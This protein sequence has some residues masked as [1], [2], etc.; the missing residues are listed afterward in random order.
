MP[1]K[2]DN[3][4]NR[5]TVHVHPLGTSQ[6]VETLVDPKAKLERDGGK[7]TVRR[8]NGS[9]IGTEERQGQL[10]YYLDCASCG[11]KTYGATVLRR[12][13]SCHNVP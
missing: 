10:M 4:P 2:E 6:L 11:I 8:R 12:C 7:P 13:P 3:R 1:S 9:V 5:L